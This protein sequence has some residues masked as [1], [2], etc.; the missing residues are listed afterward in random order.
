MSTNT[1]N[2]LVQLS[3]LYSEAEAGK[4]KNET[5]QN[6]ELVS[7]ENNECCSVSLKDSFLFESLSVQFHWKVFVKQFLS[8]TIIPFCFLFTNYRGQGFVRTKIRHLFYLYINVGFPIFVYLMLISY[9]L[10]SKESQQVLSG[11]FWIPLLY[12]VQHKLTVALK[13]ATLS[14]DEYLKFQNCTDNRLC[15][16]YNQQMQLLSSWYNRDEKV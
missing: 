6:Q 14:N 13:Y 2:P 10:C 9:F 4:V 8:H 1:A 11:A 12:F 7:D 3:D 16:L 5:I 15:D